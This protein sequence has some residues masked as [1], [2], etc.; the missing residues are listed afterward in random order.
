MRDGI[1]PAAM[2]LMMV[3]LMLGRQT[4]RSA[5]VAALRSGGLAVAFSLIPNVR[6]GA[7]AAITACCAVTALVSIPVYWPRLLPKWAIM[8]VAIFAGVATGLTL[9][10]TAASPGTDLA[11][12]GLLTLLPASIAER[13]GF[14]VAT[15]VVASWLVAVAVL[16]SALPL[17][18]VH[19]G[20]VPD[21]RG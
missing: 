20:Y 21:H 13:N 19:P 2:L 8:I 5:I 3:G 7:D 18:I 17:V 9:A 10:V 15:R 4:L 14:G 6:F 1:L 16:A 12:L 11:I